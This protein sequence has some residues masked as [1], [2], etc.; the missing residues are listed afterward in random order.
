MKERPGVIHIRDTHNQS[1]YVCEFLGLTRVCGRRKEKIDLQNTFKRIEVPEELRE[2][3][4][5]SP[6]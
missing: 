1:G 3:L 6:V 4:E 5:Q 2:M